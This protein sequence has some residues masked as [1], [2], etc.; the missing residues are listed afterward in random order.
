MVHQI[1]VHPR[2]L[3][4]LS[5]AEEE[6]RELD[7]A[8]VLVRVRH[9][10]LGP[11]IGRELGLDEQGSLLLQETAL[12]EPARLG[13]VSKDSGKAGLALQLVRV[14]EGQRAP[15]PAVQYD[16]GLQPGLRQLRCCKFNA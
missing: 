16:G 14:Q 12:K 10:E 11:Q 13:L 7:F 9:D 8:A 15:L 5:L 2:R 6:D 3:A 1:R 4:I